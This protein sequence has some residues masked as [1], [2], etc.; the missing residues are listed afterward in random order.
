[1]PE[2]GSIVI[3]TVSGVDWPAIVAS[4]S[5]GLAALAGIGGTVWLAKRGSDVQLRIAREQ[6]IA[7]RQIDTY[8]DMLK[9]IRH[10][11]HYNQVPSFIQLMELLTLPQELE[12]NVTAFAEGEVRRR[13]DE[14]T[15]A[16]I[17]MLTKVQDNED[18]IWK[19]IREAWKTKN[20]EPIFEAVPEWRT[21]NDAMDALRASIRSELLG[22]SARDNQPDR[23]KISPGR[24]HKRDGK[25]QLT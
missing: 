18:Q 16:W 7:E 2:T 21:A 12:L 13:M 17:T 19:L 6:R 10:I 1:M 3:Q 11:E 25:N 5:A 23:R 14:F 15:S 24:A 9:W 20:S 8:L 4:L 22:E